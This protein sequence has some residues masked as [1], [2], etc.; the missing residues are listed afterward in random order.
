MKRTSNFKNSIN[1]VHSKVGVATVLCSV[2]NRL[3]SITISTATTT[4]TTPVWGSV[5]I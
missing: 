1:Y 3:V 4:T 5:Y 2:E